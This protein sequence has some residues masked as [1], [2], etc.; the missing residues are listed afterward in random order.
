MVIACVRDPS[1]LWEIV[2]TRLVQHLPLTELQWK[3]PTGVFKVIPF[4]ELIF[5]LEPMRSP[6]PAI[7]ILLFLCDDND[8][9][10]RHR[11]LIDG[12]LLD[13]VVQSQS[14]LI[15]LVSLGTDGV[16]SLS[17]GSRP[18]RKVLEKIETD[19]SDKISSG[20]GQ[21]VLLDMVEQNTHQDTLQ[22]DKLMNAIKWCIV[23][24]CE[25]RS[26]EFETKLRALQQRGKS[27][28]F[29]SY[30]ELKGSYSLF[31]KELLLV[32][33]A[34]RQ[35]DELDAMLD[36]LELPWSP[37]PKDIDWMVGFVFDKPPPLPPSPFSDDYASYI[38]SR[39]IHLLLLMGKYEEIIARTECFI[40]SV[41][42]FADSTKRCITTVLVTT[43]IARLCGDAPSPPLSLGFGSAQL[44]SMAFSTIEKIGVSSNFVDFRIENNAFLLPSV[45]VLPGDTTASNNIGVDFNGLQIALSSR[46]PFLNT[47]LSFGHAVQSAF[48]VIGRKR[49]SAG[50]SYRIGIVLY[51]KGDVSRALSF[52]QHGARINIR[53][54]WSHVNL[55]NTLMAAQCMHCL[56]DFQGYIDAS[57]R[58]FRIDTAAHPGLHGIAKKFIH[59]FLQRMKMNVSVAFFQRPS[60]S[61][62]EVSSVKLKDARNGLHS[63]CDCDLFVGESTDLIICLH[64]FCEY[65]LL[66]SRVWLSFE[67]IA[68]APVCE[69][70]DITVFKGANNISFSAIRFA[71]AGVFSPT[72]VT[73]NLHKLELEFK[74]DRDIDRWNDIHILQ[75]KPT[76]S[77]SVHVLCDNPIL[78]KLVPMQI[79]ISSNFDVMTNVS[80]TVQSRSSLAFRENHEIKVTSSGSGLGIETISIVPFVDGR[81]DLPDCDTGSELKYQLEILPPDENNLQHMVT[82]SLSYTVKSSTLSI[83]KTVPVAFS[84]P[85]VMSHSTQSVCDR[86]F[87]QLIFTCSSDS[88]VG[89][90]S[91]SF[92]PGPYEF[93]DHNFPISGKSV[94]PANSG[95]SFVF[96]ILESSHKDEGDINDPTFFEDFASS[97]HFRLQCLPS[98][99]LST[100]LD[101]PVKL[102]AADQLPS[103]NVVV[104]CQSNCLIGE[105]MDFSF[106]VTRAPRSAASTP[107]MN[108]NRDIIYKVI[109]DHEQWMFSGKVIG[110]VNLNNGVVIKGKLVPVAC[111]S[112]TVPAIHL[113]EVMMDTVSSIATDRISFQFESRQ[114]LVLH[115]GSYSSNCAKL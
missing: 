37:Q 6:S 102:K 76:A 59:E 89:L 20:Q 2:R 7:S 39:Q 25:R 24:T 79:V 42:R 69:V 19:L 68:A 46:E 61:I 99:G 98:N 94:V 51:R 97:G 77:L 83:S 88:P 5:E 56:K 114:V 3:D 67:S 92:H 10:R 85:L 112:L 100:S 63:A 48:S 57:I 65:D 4:V 45:T 27:V 62:L 34:L 33:D 1:G 58:L 13:I 95:F 78:G 35:F 101:F 86:T 17:R 73:F 106:H 22:T 50:F 53:S 44:L 82:A 80:M 93:V 47:Y 15:I 54:C 70:F 84:S 32:D 115:Q 28:E 111:G 49:F 103:Y 41:T 31:Y 104:R 109:V 36:A 64:S 11:S 66:I 40:A 14:W 60:G 87:L 43:A 21:V 75:R 108:D 90:E 107:T 12:F 8:G 18:T 9:Y 96:E 110:R 81:I 71:S 91:Y 30:C 52:F 55:P 72:S 23:K 16:V 113:A 38:F 74:P 29:T 105:M 26:V